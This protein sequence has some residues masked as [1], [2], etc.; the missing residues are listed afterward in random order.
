MTA[1]T[2][3][4]AEPFAVVVSDDQAGA[5]IVTSGAQGPPGRNGI[6]GADISAEPD[7]QLTAKD[8]G[9]YVPPT[10]WAQKE[11]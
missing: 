5:V 11:W 4:Y 3:A 7:N 1:K 2:I 8:D 6:G 10:A 9:L